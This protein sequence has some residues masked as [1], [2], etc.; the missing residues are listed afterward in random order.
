MSK[1]YSKEDLQNKSVE[2]LEQIKK[3]LLENKSKIA[4]N[5]PSINNTYYVK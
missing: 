1:K 2:E 4:K 5:P 3:Q